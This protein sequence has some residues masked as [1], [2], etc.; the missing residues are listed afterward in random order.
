MLLSGRKWCDFVSFDPRIISDLG[1][2]I[3]R[4]NANEEVIERMTEKVKLAR[5]LFNQYFESFNG[6]KS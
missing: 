5:I 3:Y 6:K 4:V 1:L 2:F